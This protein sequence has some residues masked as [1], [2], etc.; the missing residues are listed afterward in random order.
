MILDCISDDFNLFLNK[1]KFSSIT[2]M[3][4]TKEP[5]AD[6]LY[7]MEKYNINDIFTHRNPSNNYDYQYFVRAVNRF[8][9]LM[10]SSESKLFFMISRDEHNIE[11]SFEMMIE[12]LSDETQ[13]FNLLC[14][15]LNK[16]TLIEGTFSV[17]LEKKYSS[18]DY[19]LL[20]H[21]LMN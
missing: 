15:Q 13:N 20:H 10:K 5:G 3:R 4:E 11:E 2:H 7:Y 19:I 1:E 21:H 17:N 8:R 12:N 14:I 16:P 6:Y 18:I 9:S